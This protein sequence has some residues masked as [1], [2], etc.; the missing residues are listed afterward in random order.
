MVLCLFIPPLHP[1]N[2][3]WC[4]YA[5]CLYICILYVL[6]HNWKHTEDSLSDWLHL[7]FSIWFRDIFIYIL[8]YILEASWD[9]SF[10]C[11]NNIL[12]HG[13]RTT[14]P[15]SSRKD[16]FGCFLI[17]LILKYFTTYVCRFHLWIYSC[18]YLFS[19]LINFSNVIANYMLR[20]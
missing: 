18:L 7:Y 8:S 9:I 11:G 19:Y 16:L 13:C 15:H 3:W 10:N 14:F 4:L 17:F 2:A 12:L 6:S 1:S 20:P 5:H